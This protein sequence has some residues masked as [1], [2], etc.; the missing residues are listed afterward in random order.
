MNLIRDSL[1]EG[2]DASWLR[3]Q[4]QPGLELAAVCERAAQ[5]WLD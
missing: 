4:R 2:N 5:R 3:A 1:F